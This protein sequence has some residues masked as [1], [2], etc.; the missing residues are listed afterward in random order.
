MFIRKVLFSLVVFF[1]AATPAFSQGERATL[2]GS[3]SDASGAVIPDADV[4][5]TNRATNVKTRTQTTQVGIYY[6]SA[7]PPGEYDLT[8]EGEGFRQALVSNIPLSTG[9]T[10]TIDVVMQ[11]GAVTET[12]EVQATAVQLLMLAKYGVGAQRAAPAPARHSLY[13]KTTLYSAS[14]NRVTDFGTERHN[15]FAKG[16]RIADPWPQPVGVFR[17]GAWR[18]PNAGPS[19]RWQRRDR[20]SDQ[21]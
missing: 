6:L 14:I 2:T 1:L 11:I 17:A 19:R 3:V 18:H 20:P 7:L 4:V 8:V 21:L 5:I 16:C 13:P 10:A 9:L 15:R 12:V